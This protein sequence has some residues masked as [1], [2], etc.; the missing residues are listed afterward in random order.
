MSSHTA[1]IVGFADVTEL[2]DALAAAATH[3][4]AAAQLSLPFVDGE[5]QV[6]VVNQEFGLVPASSDVERGY[7][8]FLNR[9]T[10]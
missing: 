7:V 6:D 8:G 9:G 10:P 4:M 5:V 2:H 1:Q 3:R